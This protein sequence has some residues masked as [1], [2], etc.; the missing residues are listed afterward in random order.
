MG[1]RLEWNGFKGEW[2]GQTWAQQIQT[3]GLEFALQKGHKKM[4]QW[5][6]GEVGSDKVCLL[7]H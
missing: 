5:L 2:E 7:F 6:V 3:T 1:Q 4:G